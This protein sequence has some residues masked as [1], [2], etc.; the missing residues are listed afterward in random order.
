VCP[1]AAICER[2]CYA[3]STQEAHTP[4]R[5]CPQ[6]NQHPVPHQPSTKP[7]PAAISCAD[8]TPAPPPSPP[9][10][11]PHAAPVAGAAKI[12]DG[13]QIAEDI[14][15][16]IAAEVA[17]L[18]AA[19]GRAPGLAVVLV[20]TRKD[21]ET[22]VRSKKKACAEVGGSVGGLTLW[23]LGVGLHA[24]ALGCMLWGPAARALLSHRPPTHF[25]HCP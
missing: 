14:R 6:P 12:I 11:A 17:G 22:Y 3:T 15:K 19:T 7:S 1:A 5:Q 20:G 8:L 18:K 4:S 23:A 10:P 16:E 2:P 25:P 9:P 13:K 24:G 21:S